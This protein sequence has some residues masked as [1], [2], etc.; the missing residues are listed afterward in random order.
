MDSKNLKLPFENRKLFIVIGVLITAIILPVICFATIWKP[1]RISIDENEID[2][3]ILQG[4]DVQI[5][6]K[7]LSGTIDK[8]IE[9]VSSKKIILNYINNL[10]N[11]KYYREGDPIIGTPSFQIKIFLHDGSK[12]TIE[13]GGIIVV[14]SD[15]SEKWYE[16]NDSFQ[17][18][19]YELYIENKER[20]NPRSGCC[21]CAT[22]T[23]EFGRIFTCVVI[24]GKIV[25]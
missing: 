11:L 7:L 15:A 1:C 6:D 19:F 20:K 9:N 18:L 22:A 5:E 23:F 12:I 17:M 3:I 25:L 13:E 14:R 10:D 21:N 4:V 16:A 2:Y 24:Y 8:T